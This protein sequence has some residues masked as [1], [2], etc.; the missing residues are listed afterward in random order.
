MNKRENIEQLS[1]NFDLYTGKSSD[2]HS[3]KRMLSDME[4]LYYDNKAFRKEVESNDIIVY[5]YYIL[6]IPATPENLL[7]GTTI[8]YPGKVGNEYFMN[9]GHF[10]QILNTSEVYYCLRGEGYLL[11]EDPEGEVLIAKINPGTSVY[12]PPRF[13]HRCINVS[14]N[15]PLISFYSCRADAGHDYKTIE[16]KGFRKL[17]IEERGKPKIINNPNWE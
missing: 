8:L 7:Y 12:V 6:E 2:L 16:I 15:E 17:I 9:K 13:A 5:E 14:K 3:I 4:R 11:M 10:H 1:I